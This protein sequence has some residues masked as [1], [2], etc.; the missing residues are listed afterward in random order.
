[1]AKSRFRASPGWPSQQHASRLERV[2]PPACSWHDEMGPAGA[3][4]EHAHRAAIARACDTRD[5]MAARRAAKE[6]GFTS[7]EGTTAPPRT[8]NR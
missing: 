1:M 7:K 5:V 3:A 6:E 4:I 2:S 8:G